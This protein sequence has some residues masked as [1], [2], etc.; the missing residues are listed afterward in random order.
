[1]TDQATLNAAAHAV[2]PVAALLAM[3]G[4]L[5]VSGGRAALTL[6]GKDQAMKKRK[7]TERAAKRERAARRDWN[8][9]QE[10]V[11]RITHCHRCGAEPGPQHAPAHVA[12][13]AEVKV[14]EAMLQIPSKEVN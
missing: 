9:T 5:A 12:W 3:V 11:F 6:I 1:M 14:L 8:V 10:I 2:V 13:A 7:S 4:G